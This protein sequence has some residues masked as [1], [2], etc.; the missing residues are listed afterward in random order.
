MIENDYYKLLGVKRDAGK[1]DI[2]RAYYAQVKIYSPEK[3]PERFKVLRAAYEFLSDDK[4]RADYDK[5][6]A[7]PAKIADAAQ[8]AKRLLNNAQYAEAVEL[9]KKHKKN[10]VLSALLAEA[11]LGNGNSGMAVKLAEEL[12][13]RRPDD[14][15]VH[16]LLTNA[17]MSRGYNNKA[18]SVISDAA[19][20][21]PDSPAV[22]SKYIWANEKMCGYIPDDYFDRIEPIADQLAKYNFETFMLCMQKEL[23]GGVKERVPSLYSHYADGLLSAGAIHTYQYENAVLITDDLIYN[24]ECYKTA[25]RLAPFLINHKFRNEQKDRLDRIGNMVELNG[26]MNKKVM[27]S[28]LINYLMLLNDLTPGNSGIYE[29]DKF[30]YEYDL[31]CN[32]ENIRGSLFTLRDNYPRFF[33]MNKAFFMDLMNPTM[34]R[35]LRSKYEKLNK[36]KHY[37]TEDDD[38]LDDLFDVFTSYF[39]TLPSKEKSKILKDL[40]KDPDSFFSRDNYEAVDNDYFEEEFG[41]PGEPFVRAERKI[42]R[43]EICP[44]GSGKKY[45]HC[46][47]RA[48]AKAANQ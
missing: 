1:A 28:D 36:Q 43:N 38:S 23:K 19:D 11:Y 22:I 16:V 42:G 46:C 47:G 29:K 40:Q 30:L 32:A 17:Y 35:K 4:K 10:D 45:K 27:D 8:E 25:E 2:K 37:F 9:L 39:E 12:I 41:E 6:G 31:V 13:K 24:T 21:F 26:L 33:E 18:I 15:E 44:C 34:H 20:K 7:Q 48:G 5:Y 14:P 3:D